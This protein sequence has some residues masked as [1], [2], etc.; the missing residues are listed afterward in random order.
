MPATLEQV[1]KILGSDMF[2]EGEKW[3]VK[4]QFRLLGDFETALAQAI[5]KAD[6]KNLARLAL[7]FPT[8]ID[9]FRRWAYGTLGDKLRA[10]GL[11]I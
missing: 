6:D 11:N 4:W 3:V 10:A 8:Q 7:G 1:G 9:G 5:I 2:D